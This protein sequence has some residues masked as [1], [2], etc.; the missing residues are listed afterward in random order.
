MSL[1]VIL[2]N[3]VNYRLRIRDYLLAFILGILVMI[4]EDHQRAALLVIFNRSSGTQGRQLPRVPGGVLK[5]ED[6]AFSR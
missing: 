4:E 2:L 1:I 5:T 6:R 3:L